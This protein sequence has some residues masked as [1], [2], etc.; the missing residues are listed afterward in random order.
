MPSV[1]TASANV[2]MDTLEMGKH[3]QVSVIVYY[4]ALSKL[5]LFW[6]IRSSTKVPS[7]N[8]VEDLAIWTVTE[9]EESATL[10][11]YNYIYLPQKHVFN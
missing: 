2:T 3:A 11:H 8:L 10:S 7:S 9:N 5:V 1:L 6:L 4:L